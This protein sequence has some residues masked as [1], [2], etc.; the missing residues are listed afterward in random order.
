LSKREDKYCDKCGLK[1]EKLSVV[2][3]KSNHRE[4]VKL[5]SVEWRKNHKEK[6]KL[7]RIKWNGNHRK[8]M[9][10]YKKNLDVC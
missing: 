10:L 4:E 3:W 9:N 7:S 1:E 6:E 2:V 8:E 5:Y